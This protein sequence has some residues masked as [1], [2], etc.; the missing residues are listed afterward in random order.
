MGTFFKAYLKA[1]NIELVKKSIGKYYKIIR[2]EIDTIEQDW[3]YGLEGSDTLILSK[4]YNEDWVEITL[5]YR[6]SLYF[7]DE[8]LRRLSKD[9]NSEILLGYYQSTMG[10]GRLAK[11]E[12]GKLK[13]SII[14][15]EAGYKENAMLR[16]VDNRGITD[17][18]KKQFLIPKIGEKFCVID[19]DVIYNFYKINGLEWDGKTR[20]EETYFY[21]EIKHD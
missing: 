18:L 20:E 6:F 1:K 2:E 11:F 10:Q 14:Q 21:L 16:L 4:N 8:L 9:F 19:C 13:L 17:E 7:H 12:N 3:R 5:S 15:S